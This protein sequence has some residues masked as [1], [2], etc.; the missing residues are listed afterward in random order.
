[1]N[2]V[3][4]LMYGQ[5]KIDLLASRARQTPPS[6]AIAAPRALHLGEAVGASR[7]VSSGVG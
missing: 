2:L 4:R 1:V 3:K 5:G 6:L 7:P